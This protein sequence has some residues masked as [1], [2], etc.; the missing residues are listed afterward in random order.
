MNQ[1]HQCQ[2]E[3]I[4]L[5]VQSKETSKKELNEDELEMS[6]SFEKKHQFT[7]FDKSFCWSEHFK[8]FMLTQD[9]AEGFH[10][11]VENLHTHIWSKVRRS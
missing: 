9:S 7:T 3:K 4:S 2:N 5:V 1:V 11:L 6:K 8:S 10:C